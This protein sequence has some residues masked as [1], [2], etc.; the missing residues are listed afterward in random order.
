M[1]KKSFSLIVAIVLFSLVLSACTRPASTPPPATETPGDFP[2][3]VE[4]QQGLLEE[5]ASQTAEAKEG[6]IEATP[7]AGGGQSTPVE[8]E[9]AGGGAPE[10]PA[11]GAPAEQAPAAVELPT[12]TRPETYTLLKGEWPICIARRYDLPLDTLFTI[13]NLTM[14]SKPAVGTVLQIPQ[15]GSWNAGARSL[16]QHPGSYVVNAGDSVNS[17]ACYYGDVDPAGIIALNS[18]QPPYSLTTGQTLQIP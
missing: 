3:F 2:F 1:C 4:T 10:Q 6:P 12:L 11:E 17:I 7:Q 9:Q 14:Q 16:H 5:A 18:L 8:D 13:N 15:S